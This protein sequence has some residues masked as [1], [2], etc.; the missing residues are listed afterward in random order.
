MHA[1]RAGKSYS[2]VKLITKYGVRTDT[3]TK[4]G[5]TALMIAIKEYKRLCNMFIKT[6]QG[7]SGDYNIKSSKFTEAIIMLLLYMENHEQLQLKAIGTLKDYLRE[8][9]I[10]TLIQFKEIKPTIP[11]ILPRNI[12]VLLSIN[13]ILM[14][15]RLKRFKSKINL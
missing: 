3:M 9:M 5:D 11:K 14:D 15:Y 12:I 10:W 1:A 13:N 4:S 7:S 6:G 2:I 8:R